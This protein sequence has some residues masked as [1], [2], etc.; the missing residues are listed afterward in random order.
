MLHTDVAEKEGGVWLMSDVD[1]ARL[2]RAFET[3]GRQLSV[4]SLGGIAK[5]EARTVEGLLKAEQTLALAG[6]SA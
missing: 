3:F 4:A 5:A 6:A 2:C 1:Y